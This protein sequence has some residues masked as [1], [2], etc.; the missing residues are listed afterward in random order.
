ML[1][2][3]INWINAISPIKGWSLLAFLL[4]AAA[5][6]GEGWMLLKAHE[7]IG[8]KDAQIKQWQKAIEIGAKAYQEQQASYERQLSAERQRLT[9][10]QAAETK[11]KR[12]QEAIK[13]APDPNHTLDSNL[14]PDVWLPIIQRAKEYNA[15][16]GL[17]S[18]EAVPTAGTDTHASTH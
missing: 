11:T 7:D 10:Y 18:T 2:K 1:S 9:D 6:A 5:T 12:Q 13:N 15:S 3:A 8:G 17:P 16:H 4:L 14:G